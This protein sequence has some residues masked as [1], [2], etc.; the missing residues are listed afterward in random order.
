MS[1]Q[2]RDCNFKIGEGKLGHT[3]REFFRKSLKSTNTFSILVLDGSRFPWLGVRV[4]RSR[5]N[6]RW[7]KE[8]NEWLGFESEQQSTLPRE[9]APILQNKTTLSNPIDHSPPWPPLPLLYCRMFASSHFDSLTHQSNPLK[10]SS[11]PWLNMNIITL[12]DH[13]LFLG[14]GQGNLYINDLQQ[15]ANPR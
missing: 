4:R 11:G 13:S 14:L 10:K 3:W 12:T 8:C 2:L 6:P 1:S 5:G 7:L 15:H 9:E